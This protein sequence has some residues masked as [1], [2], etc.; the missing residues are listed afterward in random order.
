VQAFLRQHLAGKDAEALQNFLGSYG[1]G[2]EAFTA[3]DVGDGALPH[4]KL[5]G[6]DGR[7][8]QSFLSG[9]GPIDPPKLEAAVAAALK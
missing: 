3:F 5:Y 9:G 4:V 7:L 2:S 6:R 1:V 8:P